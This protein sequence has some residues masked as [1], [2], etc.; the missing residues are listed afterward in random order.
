MLCAIAWMHVR[1]C[2][3]VCLGPVRSIGGAGG[4][5]GVDVRRGEE[6]W[7]GLLLCN[8]SWTVLAVLS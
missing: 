2:V 8:H 1:V 3:C 6:V 7:S 4:G 5:G